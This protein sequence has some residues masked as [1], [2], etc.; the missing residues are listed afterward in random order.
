MAV[1]ANVEGAAACE[2]LETRFWSKRPGMRGIGERKAAHAEAG[3][4]QE[5]TRNVRH[6]RVQKR[7]RVSHI[8]HVLNWEH[9]KLRRLVRV[10]GKVAERAEIDA[11]GVSQVVAI[12]L[13]A[14]AKHRPLAST[15]DLLGVVSEIWRECFIFG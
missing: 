8:V 9:S 7:Y 6:A 2:F 10:C 4:V 13:L 15:R 12:V 1:E 11:Q 5:R 14:A 3:I